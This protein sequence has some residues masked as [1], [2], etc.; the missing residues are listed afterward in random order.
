MIEYLNNNSAIGS[1]AKIKCL[2]GYILNL[3]RLSDGRIGEVILIN[4]S[5][6]SRPLIKCG[7]D[8]VDLSLEPPELYI[9]SIL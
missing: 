8:Y 5:A 6:L 2:D 7:T 1:K 3:V 4:R 9:D